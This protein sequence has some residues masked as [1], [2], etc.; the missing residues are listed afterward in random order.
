M[1]IA[2]RLSSGLELAPAL[3]ACSALGRRQRRHRSRRARSLCCNSRAPQ[4]T[5]EFDE[6]LGAIAISQDIIGFEAQRRVVTRRGR[7]PDAQGLRE[8]SPDW[9][10][11]S[12]FPCAT[13][14][15]TWRPELSNAKTTPLRLDQRLRAQPNGRPAAPPAQ[16]SDPLAEFDSTPNSSLAKVSVGLRTRRI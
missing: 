10:W 13:A 3:R 4:R 11:A 6:R 9:L 12:A 2:R 8:H 14:S 1:M 5:L 16:V 15:G 7:R